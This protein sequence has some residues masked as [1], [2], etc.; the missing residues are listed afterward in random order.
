MRV[1]IVDADLIGRDKHRFPNLVCE[2]LSGYW[3]QQG[4]EVDLLLDYDHFDE[5]DE[6]YIAKVFTD[7]PVPEWLKETEHIHI[8]GTG[9]YFDKAP[10]LPDAIEH[11]MPDYN[12]YNEWIESEVEKAKARNTEDFNEKRFRDQFK[13]YTDY[14]IGFMTRGCF[15]KCPFCVNQKYD[16]VFMHSPLEEFYDKSRKKI[17]LLDDNFL[18]C[19]NWKNI[20]NQLIS[21]DRPFKFKQG[22]D[23]RLLTD[24]KCKRL[25]SAKYDGDYT[26]AFDNISDYDLIHKRLRI[27]RKYTSAINIKFYVLVGFESTDATDIENAFKR[28]ELLMRFK[29]IP[30]VMRYQN[31]NYT[32]WKE[33]EFRA[34]YVTLA[35]WG[36]QPSI[37]KKMSFRQFCLANQHL[38]KTKGTL[39][40][41][42]RAMTEFERKYPK[43]AKKYFDLR[44]E[45]HYLTNKGADVW[46][47][48]N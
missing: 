19:P 24:E 18:G 4:A 7:T 30:Y 34:M 35:R 38:H 16:H 9:F 44:F 20:L 29:C 15:R 13:E 43:I 5:Y 45:D 33:S 48:K 3:K 22:I 27:I 32:P 26:F 31:K 17:C 28:I 23:E 25:F 8:G 14:S 41:S 21:L 12:L 11:H 47:I 10:N 6:V 36:N 39:C 2:K 37:F 40:S 42:M 46:N 1:G